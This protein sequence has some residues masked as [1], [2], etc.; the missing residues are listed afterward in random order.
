MRRMA[1]V[2]AAMSLLLCG[3]FLTRPT[4]QSK[5]SQDTEQAKAKTFSGKIVSQNGVRFVL[6]DE[7]N[8]VWY[9]LDD[10]EK[11]GKLVGKDVLVTGKFDGLT[12]TIRVQSIVESP[13]L[14][15]PA[16]NTE[17][18][19]QNSEPAKDVAAPPATADA[20][21]PQSTTVEKPVGKV[22][23]P[24]SV[25]PIPA[26]TEVS[27]KP[28]GGLPDGPAP[29]AA[30]P[31]V[32]TLPEEAVSSSSSIAISSRRSVPIP[33]GF[34]PETQSSKNLVSGRLLKR[35]DPA[36]PLEAMQQRIEG[37]VQLHA[38]IGDDG[39]VLSVEPVSGPPLLVE[40]AVSAVR[41]WRY[42]PSLSDGHRVQ[43][44]EDIT[45]VFRLPD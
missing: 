29:E 17:E 32:L 21:A 35:V 22:P 1:A 11:A 27:H 6:R 5:V 45:L 3:A 24:E 14:P 30:P 12:G 25:P 26:E 8:N 41:Q 38:V 43:I 20:A 36:Y 7:D 9:H 44:Q 40:A 19:K 16:A 31:S 18:P 39:K 2:E 42:G 28:Q 13:S 15:K 10:Q 4:T 33:S 37:T 23:A 34:N